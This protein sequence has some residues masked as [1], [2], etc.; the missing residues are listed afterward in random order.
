MVMSSQLI[1]LLPKRIDCA[2][3]SDHVIPFS[4]TLTPT[5]ASHNLQ[6]TVD[7][8]TYDGERYGVQVSLED[9]LPFRLLMRSDFVEAVYSL[10]LACLDRAQP[11]RGRRMHNK[12]H[13]IYLVRLLSA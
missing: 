10:Q 6:S 8:G 1:L 2:R 9:F 11:P 13:S 12:A 3:W 7:R 4:A 5:C